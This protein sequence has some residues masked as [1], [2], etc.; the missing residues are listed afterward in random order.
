MRRRLSWPRGVAILVIET[1]LAGAVAFPLTS[2]SILLPY[3][4][5]QS[6]RRWPK[7]DLEVERVPK[8]PGHPSVRVVTVHGDTLKA[9]FSGVRL[10]SE[11]T[12]GRRFAEWRAKHEGPLELGEPITVVPR[13][14][15][16][17]TSNFLGFG[18]RSVWIRYGRFDD[19]EYAIDQLTAIRRADGSEVDLDSLRAQA[20]RGDLPTRLGARLRFAKRL[21]PEAERYREKGWLALVPIDDV[22]AVI[23]D[24]NV[25]SVPGAFLGGVVIDG[26]ALVLAAAAAYSNSGWGSGGCNYTSPSYY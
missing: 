22:Q 24:S 15:K 6:N 12:Y 2:C 13:K 5:V 17:R 1:T 4:A 3:G 20:E 7:G 11:E 9:I 23:V 16:P 21:P 8:L 18:P 19:G 25:A 14:G 10:L 26:A